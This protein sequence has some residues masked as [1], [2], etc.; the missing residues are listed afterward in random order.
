MCLGT[1]PRGL[2]EERVMER[3]KLGLGQAGHV[4][5]QQATWIK[6]ILK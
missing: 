4:E 5:A 2:G 1:G 6:M 3:G